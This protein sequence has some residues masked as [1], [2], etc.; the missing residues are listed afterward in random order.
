MIPQKLCGPL[1]QW[2][3]PLENYETMEL[4]TN[5]HTNKCL[6]FNVKWSSPTAPSG[7]PGKKAD[8]IPS[9]VDAG[10]STSP[11]ELPATYQLVTSPTSP[12]SW[13]LRAPWEAPSPGLRADL[14]EGPSKA[15][16]A[17]AWWSCGNELPPAPETARN[18]E[19]KNW[20][21]L[22]FVLRK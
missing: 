15:T 22:N 10:T 8:T 16:S 19:R 2:L 13:A 11:P 21:L 14:S 7:A 4:K 3:E 9:P 12:S 1:G 18:K 17:R 6:I 5:K 20:R